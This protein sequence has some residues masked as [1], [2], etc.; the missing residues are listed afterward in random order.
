MGKMKGL[1]RGLDSIF[2]DNAVEEETG[3]GVRTLRMA[4]IDPKAD[5]PRRNFDAE[6]LSQLADSIA[7]NGILQPILVRETGERYEI[8]AGE[9]RFRAA[10]LAGLSEIPALVL[11]ADDEAA[12]KYALIENLQRE[13]LNPY[14]E[15]A[16]IRKLMDEYGLSQEQV[17]GSIGRSRSAVA[18]ALR[19][20]DLPEDAVKL[21]TD[22][23]LSAGH[24]RTLLGLLDKGQIGD[25]ARKCVQSA[26]SVRE[27]ESLVKKLNRLYTQQR[28]A[29]EDDAGAGEVVVDYF[30]SLENRFTSATGRRVKITETRNKKVLQLEYR[31]NEDLEE[32]L[33][34]LAGDA[35]LD[36]V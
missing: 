8:I 18:N 23:T 2:V 10:R 35:F 13:D 31:D 32:L 14:E 22:G 19:L 29:I 9:R 24:A 21:V 6:A 30:A 15:A 27:L 16:A 3:S 4:E 12:A 28:D 34:S 26:L 7:A 17:A 11:E 36:E 20:L 5:Q 33:R 25:V 1:G